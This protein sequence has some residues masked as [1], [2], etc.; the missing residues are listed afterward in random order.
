MYI[1]LRPSARVIVNR[2]ESRQPRFLGKPVFPLSRVENKL[3]RNRTVS[4]ALRG[5]VKL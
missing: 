4:L 1:F 3:G 2:R 5:F